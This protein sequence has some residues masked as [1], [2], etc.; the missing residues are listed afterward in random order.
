MAERNYESMSLGVEE[1]KP[2]LG[3]EGRYEVSNYSRVRSLPFTTVRSNGRRY[4]H[5][6]GILKPAHHKLHEYVQL[7]YSAKVQTKCW[8]YRLAL[9]AF[10]GP[11]PTDKHEVNHKDGDPLNNHISNLEWVTR[12]ENMAHAFA[13]KLYSRGEEVGCA[14]LNEQMVREARLLRKAGLSYRALGKKLG[15]NHDTIRSAVKRETWK[16]VV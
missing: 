14:V 16:H 2:V 15:V 13:N 6:G 11:P 7:Y 8:V 3:L 9:E 1:W 12:K 4:V 5:H 10:I